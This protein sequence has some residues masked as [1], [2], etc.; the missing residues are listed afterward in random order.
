MSLSFGKE[1]NQRNT[2]YMMYG[3]AVRNN[4][5]TSVEPPSQGTAR[6]P[7][8]RLSSSSG[9][10]NILS[11]YAPTLCSPAEAKDEFY[12]ELEGSVSKIP[13]TEH[14]FIL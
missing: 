11:I 14:L 2:G 5:L 13:D 9:L 4:I 7:S 3:F 6:I 8:L 10:V 1:K 12:E